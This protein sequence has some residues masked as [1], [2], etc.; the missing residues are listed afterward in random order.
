MIILCSNL[1]SSIIHFTLSLISLGNLW[2]PTGQLHTQPRRQGLQ[3]DQGREHHPLLQVSSGITS[4]YSHPYRRILILILIL[5][6]V[7][8]HV[9]L[10]ILTSLSIAR[11]RFATMAPLPL[12]RG[13]SLESTTTRSKPPAARTRTR[14]FAG[15]STAPLLNGLVPG[16]LDNG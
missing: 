14:V 11:S 2:S 1:F 12:K 9:L 15:V 16:L 4:S 10:L 8:S 7:L 3:E 6:L 5:A 13:R